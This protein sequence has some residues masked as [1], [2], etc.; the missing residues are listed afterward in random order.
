MTAVV[1]HLAEIEP[2]ADEVG[3]RPLRERDAASCRPV[4]PVRDLGQNAPLAQLLERKNHL[5]PLATHPGIHGRALLR[6]AA[7]EAM[8]SELP[9][10]PRTAPARTIRRRQGVILG[11]PGLLGPKPV[12]EAVDL[13]D[14]EAG[15]ADVEVGDKLRREGLRYE[16]DLTD[17]EWALL[18]PLMPAPRARGR[19]RT[20]LREL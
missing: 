2:V 12:D 5:G 8:L 18:E 17:A 3:E 14:G 11:R 16:T 1:D 19:P 10:I 9:E 20:D 6:V 4:P 13:R 15:H 7:D